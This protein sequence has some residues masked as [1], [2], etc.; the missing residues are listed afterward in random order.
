MCGLN[1][2]LHLSE[3]K[4]RCSLLQGAHRIAASALLKSCHRS[5]TVCRQRFVT[6]TTKMHAQGLRFLP[7]LVTDLLPYRKPTAQRDRHSS[8]A[9]RLPTPAKCHLHPRAHHSK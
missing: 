5:T 4:Q 2:V 7:P 1:L 3:P 6:R 9:E 8:E